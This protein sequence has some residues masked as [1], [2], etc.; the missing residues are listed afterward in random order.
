ML[1]DT[2]DSLGKMTAVGGGGGGLPLIDQGVYLRA[3]TASDWQ[4]GETKT[5]F[6]YHALA[7]VRARISRLVTTTGSAVR[8]QR[9][10]NNEGML[11]LQDSEKFANSSPSLKSGI[12]VTLSLSLKFLPHQ[13]RST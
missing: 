13:S 10:K 1:P 5:Y 12:D 7:Q 9:G 6:F 8:N 4:P 11:L 2:P 3:V